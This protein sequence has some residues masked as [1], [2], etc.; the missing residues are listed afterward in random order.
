MS[1][2]SSVAS[3]PEGACR[4]V[5]GLTLLQW[6][7]MPAACGTAKETTPGIS[8]VSRPSATGTAPEDGLPSRGAIVFR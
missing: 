4:L 2:T 1:K 3:P 5:P 7:K 8:R 6:L